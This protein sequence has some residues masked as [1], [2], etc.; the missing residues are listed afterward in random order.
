MIMMFTF[1][2]IGN[3]KTKCSINTCN[4]NK[5]S[6]RKQKSPFDMT[7]IARSIH[8]YF[9]LFFFIFCID[10]FF[11]FLLYAFLLCVKFNKLSNIP[12]YGILLFINKNQSAIFD[13]VTSN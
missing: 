12:I 1:A 6:Q 10:F 2:N 4:V 7:N 8:V 5:T 11:H 9:F 13:H 3:A